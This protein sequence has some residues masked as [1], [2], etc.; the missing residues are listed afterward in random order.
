VLKAGARYHGARRAAHLETYDMMPNDRRCQTRLL[1]PGA[2]L[3]LMPGKCKLTGHDRVV[4]IYDLLSIS[5]APSM[6]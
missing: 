6:I 5:A 4:C 3:L 1:R 2:D